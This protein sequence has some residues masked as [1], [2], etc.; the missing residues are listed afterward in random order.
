MTTSIQSSSLSAREA[1][2]RIAERFQG[3]RM[4]SDDEGE[5]RCEQCGHGEFNV[6]H[7]A[8]VTITS[9]SYLPCDESCETEV[10]ATKEITVDGQVTSMGCLDEEHRVEWHDKDFEGSDSPDVE[11]EVECQECL[12]AADEYQWVSGESEETND[13]DGDHWE[14]TCASCDHETEFGWSHAERAGRIWPVESSDFNP[15]LGWPEPRFHGDWKR[16]G[17]LQPMR[18]A[19]E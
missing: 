11:Y 16:R 1:A 4:A 17:W 10:A 6:T 14:V 19:G 7:V 18:S 5:Y 9:E 13:S 2:D 3:F 15:W 12:D 8:E